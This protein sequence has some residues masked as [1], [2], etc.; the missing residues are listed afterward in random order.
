M[1]FQHNKN[2]LGQ[3][4]TISRSLIFTILF[5]ISGGL[6]AGSQID[7]SLDKPLEEITGVIIDRTITFIGADFYRY[8]SDYW[9]ISFPEDPSVLTIFERPSARWGSLIWV[10]YRS[11][12]LSQLFISP[13]RNNKKKSAEQLANLVNKKLTQIRLTEMLSDTFDMD[14]DEI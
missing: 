8:F 7:Q 12:K 5:L 2:T 13:G 11:Q 9:R 3:L 1:N 4:S 14:R 10:E 6:H